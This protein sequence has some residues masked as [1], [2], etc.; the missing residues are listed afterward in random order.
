MPKT[1]YLLHLN[2]TVESPRQLTEADI[3]E[4]LATMATKLDDGTTIKCEYVYRRR[5]ITMKKF[6]KRVADWF[7]F[8]LTGKGPIADE[9]VDNDIVD[10]S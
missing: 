6:L 9:A 1:E 3:Y 8:L 4:I 2:M 5:G 10:Y 7:V